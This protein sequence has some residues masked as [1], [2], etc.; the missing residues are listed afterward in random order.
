MEALLASLDSAGEYFEELAGRI[1]VP[2]D[3][4]TYT[5]RL[6]G[7]RIG[8]YRLVNLIGRGGMGA[9]YLAERDDEQFQMKAALKL[10][11]MGL[12]SDESYDVSHNRAAD[13]QRLAQLLADRRELDQ[14]NPRGF[15]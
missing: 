9:V 10:L 13:F 8:N 6:V 12:D 14:S 2:I 3:P 15:R 11:P 4:E 1:G 5:E 7:K